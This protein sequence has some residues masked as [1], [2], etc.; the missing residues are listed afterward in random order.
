MREGTP[1]NKIPKIKLQITNKFQNSI[2]NCQKEFG[3]WKLNFNHAILINKL[4]ETSEKF[5]LIK[6]LCQTDPLVNGC[7]SLKLSLNVIFRRAQ[8]GSKSNFQKFLIVK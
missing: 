4:M 6:Q 1:I 8:D 5:N 3:A 7:R 2:L